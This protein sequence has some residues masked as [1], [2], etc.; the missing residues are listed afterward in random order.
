MMAGLL[1]AILISSY[2]IFTQGQH[3]NQ[4]KAEQISS[5]IT[6]YGNKTKVSLP[7]GSQVWLNAGSRLDYNNSILIKP[8]GKL[9]YAGRPILTLLIMNANHSSY[10][11]VI[12]VSGYWEQCSMSKPILKSKIL[13]QVL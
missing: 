1:F 3:A 5:V 7:D 13:K 6:K 8:C 12:C 10:V 11:P 4:S 9:I 2:F